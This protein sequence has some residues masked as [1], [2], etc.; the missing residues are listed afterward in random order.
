MRIGVIG[1]GTIA[2]AVVRG[3]AITHEQIIVGRRSK[4]NSQ[5]LANQFSNVLVEDNQ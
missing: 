4:Q 2:T 3:G 1:T 5:S